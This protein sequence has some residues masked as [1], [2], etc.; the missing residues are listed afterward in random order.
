MTATQTT[1][2]RLIDINELSMLWNVPRATLYN[3]VNQGRIPYLKIGRCL[4]F[5]VEQIADFQNRC[6]KAQP[7]SKRKT[8]V[9]EV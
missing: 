2:Q 9:T 8:Y 4:R 3:W 1:L 7:T 5:S 6:T